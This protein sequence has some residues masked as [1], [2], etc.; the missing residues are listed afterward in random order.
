MRGRDF[1]G[2]RQG[3]TSQHA[4]TAA[5][6]SCTSGGGGFSFRRQTD[7]ASLSTLNAGQPP[8]ASNRLDR[9]GLV[10]VGRQQIENDVGVEEP[11]ASGV[12]VLF[13]RL[14][15][16]KRKSAG[17][18]PKPAQTGR[19]A[20]RAAPCGRP[21][22]VRSPDDVQLDLLALLQFQCL[23][24]RCWQPDGERISPFGDLHDGRFPQIYI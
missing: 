8:C 18:L 9:I 19:A 24:H 15:R 1:R 14:G 12:P 5:S 4:L 16:S 3:T 6:S 11:V 21:P 23:N 20:P 2:K 17:S 13:I 22:S 10:L 7:A